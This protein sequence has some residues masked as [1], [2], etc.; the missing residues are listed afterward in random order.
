MMIMRAF[1]VKLLC[2]ALMGRIPALECLLVGAHRC[3]WLR[4]ILYDIKW[5]IFLRV[6]ALELLTR[7]W[8]PLGMATRGPSVC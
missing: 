3:L 1:M 2:Q 7:Y 8:Q 4:L 5:H 6:L